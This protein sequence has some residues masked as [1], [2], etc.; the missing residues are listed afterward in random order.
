[1]ASERASAYYGASK[2]LRNNSWGG[3][4]ADIERRLA[5][6]D[7]RPDLRFLSFADRAITSE[8]WVV[9]QSVLRCLQCSVLD[10][11]RCC[12][13]DVS[14]LIALLPDAPKTKCFDLAGNAL[15]ARSVRQLSAA[16]A[17][18]YAPFRPAWISVGADAQGAQ[19]RRSK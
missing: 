17:A 1:M 11:Q 7:L 4:L 18:T 2:K 6:G 9:L 14:K 19:S 3:V 12:I 16:V 8:G 10:L 5:C 13:K 15:S